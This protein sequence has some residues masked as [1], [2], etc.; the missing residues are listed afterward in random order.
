MRVLLVHNRYRQP[1]GEERHLDL[2]A[3]SLEEAGVEVSR[4]DVD[5]ASIGSVAARLGVFARL[6]YN[7]RSERLVRDAAHETRA[8]VVHFHNL[9]P[10]LTPA[11]LKGARQA[12]ARVV[13][14]A[15]NYR[16]ACPLGTLLRHGEVHDDCVTGSSLLCGL[17]AARHH[18]LQP[19]A[20]GAALQV[21]RWLRMLDRWVDGFIVPAELMRTALVR[22]GSKRARVHL[23]PLGVPGARPVEM[24]LNG[25]ACAL[26]AGR[27]SEEK[28][29]WTLLQA[30]RLAPD[31]RIVVAGS[32]PL[33]EPLRRELPPS[34]V[35]AGQVD[36]EE[37]AVLRAESC[38]SLLP[39]ECL[40]VSPYSAL[41]SGAA[42]RPV[43]AS[44]IGGLPEIVVDGETGILVPPR[45]PQELAGAMRKLW[46]DR[47]LAARLGTGGAERIRSKHS[48][49]RAADEHVALYRE[50][51][52]A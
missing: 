47:A 22:A 52:R 11:A 34:V 3:F 33:E 29:L 4:L 38:M 24:P 20:Y 12:G 27:L 17:R 31:V 42:G 37:L 50:V 28:G 45:D 44:R 39:S 16:F 25:T 36:R 32:G 51:M 13:L 19:V 5:S 10:I 35:L 21:Q 6:A 7:R 1:G 30:A 43:V 18:G 23:V 40:E 26:Y 9:W 48:L 14:T 2:L 15:H 41:E 49:V 8:H 46:H